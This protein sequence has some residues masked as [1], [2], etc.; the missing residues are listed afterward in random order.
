[1]NIR[2]KPIVPGSPWQ[3]GFAER[4]IRYRRHF[5][6]EQ[7]VRRHAAVGHALVVGVTAKCLDRRPRQ[8]PPARLANDESYAQEGERKN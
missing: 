8:E 6:L 3:N 5:A 2:D 1:M 7:I 4:L